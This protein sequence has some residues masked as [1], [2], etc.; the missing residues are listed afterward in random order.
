MGR[1]RETAIFFPD[2]LE[3]PSTYSTRV[4]PRVLFSCQLGVEGAVFWGRGLSIVQ[5]V[6]K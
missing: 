2:H 1:H 6:K 5:L 3:S 4:F